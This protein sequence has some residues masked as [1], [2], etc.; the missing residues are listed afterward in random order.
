MADPIITYDD[1]RHLADN[2]LRF[3]TRESLGADTVNIDRLQTVLEPLVSAVKN[4][5]V[6]LE[7]HEIV[8]CDLTNAEAMMDRTL[9]GYS[10]SHRDKDG[11]ICRVHPQNIQSVEHIDGNPLNNDPNN[12]RIVIDSDP[13]ADPSKPVERPLPGPYR[14]DDQGRPWRLE[15]AH[16][17]RYRHIP[18]SRIRREITPAHVVITDP[19]GHNEQTITEEEWHSWPLDF[20]PQAITGDPDGGMDAPEGM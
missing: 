16:L 18:G 4:M 12:L 2:A 11:R 10:V 7:A 6:I 14:S 13:G 1:I 19:L 15:S 17:A 3:A 9:F 8:L 5:A 20:S